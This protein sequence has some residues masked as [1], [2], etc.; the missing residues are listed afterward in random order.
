MNCERV[1]ELAP[2]LALNIASGDD[3]AEA[4]QHL[5]SCS[6]CRNEL[7]SISEV[8]DGLLFLAPPVEP[9]PGFETRVLGE[10]PSAL[11][12]WAR[13]LAAAAAVIAIAGAAA[14]LTWTAG[15][16]DRSLAADAIQQQQ[17][18]GRVNGNYF[19]AAQVRGDDGTKV[20]QAFGYDGSPSWIYVVGGRAMMG[21]RY[22]V[23]AITG[24][25]RRIDLGSMSITASDRGWGAMIPVG[26][27]DVRALRIVG[28]SGYVCTA[29]L[30]T[31]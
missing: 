18:L 5:A 20:G 8:A 27:H 24:G 10:P 23:W 6:E 29:Q 26:L 14:G 21:H 30:H 31:D 15:G 28:H 4:L 9:P 2:E 17:E 7:E 1:R 22:R 3:R 25:G 16:H 13:P 12:R 11:R 19:A